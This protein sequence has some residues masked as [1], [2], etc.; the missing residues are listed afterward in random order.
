MSL[1]PRR[2]VVPIFSIIRFQVRYIQAHE[3]TPL[4]DS[5][6]SSSTML[7]PQRKIS[8]VHTIHPPNSFGM[9]CLKRH[10]HVGVSSDDAHKLKKW[11]EKENNPGR[12]WVMVNSE[13]LSFRCHYQ[14]DV[15]WGFLFL[16][17]GDA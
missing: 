4:K 13:E 6:C 15:A 7:T 3:I 1:K 11:G 12:G 10:D 14:G 17:R 2:Q 8:K 9:P 5:T 16:L